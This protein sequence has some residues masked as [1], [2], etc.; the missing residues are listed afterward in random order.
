MRE[1]W[2]AAS[3]DSS[4]A[5]SRERYLV[6]VRGFDLEEGSLAIVACPR[7]IS[8][9]RRETSCPQCRR[10]EKFDYSSTAIER[11]QIR[12]KDTSEILRRMK[13]KGTGH[14]SC[15]R[16]VANYMSLPGALRNLLQRGDVHVME[17]DTVRPDFVPRIGGIDDDG[18]LVLTHSLYTA[19]SY[20]EKG[21]G[22]R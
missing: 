5:V 20:E 17:L 3:V 12:L 1:G 2:E 19:R 8:S 18:L 10:Q 11:E 16:D 15:L 21:Y 14:R 13:T 22:P 4:V 6:L 9:K 7:G